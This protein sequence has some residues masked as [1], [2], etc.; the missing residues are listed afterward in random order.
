METK[1]NM[2]R[3]NLTANT[4]THRD[5]HV[6]VSECTDDRTVRSES[7]VLQYRTSREREREWCNDGKNER[8]GARSRCSR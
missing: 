8:E 5:T 1:R 4:S 6:Y 7:A 2:G 3:I